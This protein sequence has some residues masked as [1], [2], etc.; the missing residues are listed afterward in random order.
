MAGD[1]ERFAITSLNLQ[2]VRVLGQKVMVTV[3]V[4]LFLKENV[5]NK[6]DDL[7]EQSMQVL[8]P[9]KEKNTVKTLGFGFFCLPLQH[10]KLKTNTLRLSRKHLPQPDG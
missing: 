10:D 2:Y 5:A 8:S 6:S 1:G 9:T 3:K 4:K 7:F